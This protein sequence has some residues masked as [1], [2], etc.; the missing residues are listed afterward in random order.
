[1]LS[2][3]DYVRLVAVYRVEDVAY[4]ARLAYAAR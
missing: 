1:M 2:L 3:C 4:E